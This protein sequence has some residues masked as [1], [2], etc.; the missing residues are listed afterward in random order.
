MKTELDLNLLS[1]KAFC[2]R[3]VWIY[4][5]KKKNTDKQMKPNVANQNTY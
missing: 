4:L 1:L 2:H 5:K 3:K